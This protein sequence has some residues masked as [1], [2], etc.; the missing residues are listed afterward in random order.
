MGET[1][2]ER[3]RDWF[4]F[5]VWFV[6][7]QPDVSC[8]LPALPLRAQDRTRIRGCL[9]MVCLLLL[10]FL[11]A[12]LFMCWSRYKIQLLLQFWRK[13]KK[14]PKYY[15]RTRFMGTMVHHKP[16]SALQ[17]LM[18][19]LW[20]GPRSWP[21]IPTVTR[22]PPHSLYSTHLSLPLMFSLRTLRKV[23]SSCSEGS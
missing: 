23:I 18:G 2:R 11:R 21:P 1:A 9:L 8:L 14:H 10:P 19:H 4:V 3:E 5:R 22:C 16:P 12:S 6:L 13:K 15:P 20:S 7:L 17:G